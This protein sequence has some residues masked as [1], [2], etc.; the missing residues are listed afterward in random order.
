[1]SMN[2][3]SG[4]ISIIVLL[5]IIGAFEMVDHKI[6]LGRQEKLGWPLRPCLIQSLSDSTW[7]NHP[8]K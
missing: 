3:N 5:D 2:T 1:M 7:P 4:K 8:K 6:L